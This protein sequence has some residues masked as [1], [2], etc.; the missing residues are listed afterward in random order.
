M[1]NF[2]KCL[3]LF[4]FIN[5]ALAKPTEIIM[6]HSLSGYL[7][8]EVNQL[9]KQ[10]NHSQGAYTV[11]PVYKGEYHEVLTSFAAAFRAKQPP[12][13]VQIFEA[14]T[15]TMLSQP[16]II[17]P[18]EELMEEQ[19][20]NFSKD[21]FLPGIR[22]FY[23][24]KDKLQAF[25]F[26][27][28]IPIIYYNAEALEQLGYKEGAFPHT[29]DDMEILAKKLVNKGFSCAY[30][31]AYPAWIEIE[32]FAA[33]HGLSMFVPPDEG[34][35]NSQLMRIQPDYNAASLKQ[36]RRLK[37]WQ[38]QR[39]F[40]YGGRDNNA[41][42]LFTSGRCPIFSQSS[43]SY[44]SLLKLVSFRLEVALLPL[45][46]T[47]SAQRHNNVVGGAA[48]WAVAG[49]SSEVNR[50]MAL[51]F[52]YLAQAPVQ[53]Q[54]YLRT[55]YLPLMRTNLVGK[56]KN[57]PVLAL[58]RVDL[59][60]NR[61]QH[62]PTISVQNQIRMI[63]DEIIEAIFADIRT[64]ELAIN[65]AEKLVNYSLRRFIKNTSSVNCPENSG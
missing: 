19:S 37:K 45:D 30:T 55:G 4:F 17:K 57:Y 6:W 31:S 21:H 1:N 18:V 35:H 44:T 47:L 40:V 10:F 15:A 26:N 48:L 39:Y 56:D 60:N 24:L 33:L 34:S 25:P 52:S 54:W 20:V 62:S 2:L 59:A 50:G 16:G 28:S 8:E 49:Q 12:A 7:G 51:F 11:K 3:C 43:G 63:Y 41:T 32:S 53:E 14:G 64:P 38:L 36:L 61:R 42:V 27:I 58:A 65:E 5:S 22:N 9:A 23:S 29:W 13:I 46:T